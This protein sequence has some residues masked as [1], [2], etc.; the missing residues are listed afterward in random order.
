MSSAAVMQH[1]WVLKHRE[2]EPYLGGV[3][4]RGETGQTCSRSYTSGS[5]QV[6]KA[7]LGCFR[8]GREGGMFTA[9]RAS[10][11]SGTVGSGHKDWPFVKQ[12]ME[13]VQLQLT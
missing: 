10:V 7:M 6:W 1:P 5:L 2:M 12:Q 3:G 9:F 4:M 8:G 13:I 11:S